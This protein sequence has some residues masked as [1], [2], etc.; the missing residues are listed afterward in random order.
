MGGTVLAIQERDVW[1]VWSLAM[2]LRDRRPHLC[3]RTDR[4]S[5]V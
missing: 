5:V 4:K 2:P 1:I 3:T